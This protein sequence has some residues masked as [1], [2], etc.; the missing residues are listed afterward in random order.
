MKVHTV[1]DA[2][3]LVI[4]LALRANTRMRWGEWKAGREL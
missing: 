4:R 2:K 3:D 1:V